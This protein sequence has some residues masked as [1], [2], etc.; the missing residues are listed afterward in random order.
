MKKKILF[1]VPILSGIGGIETSLINLVNNI[2]KEKYSVDICVY[3]NYIAFPERIPSSVK[4]IPGTK[5]MEYT[6][7]PL[8]KLSKELHGF[9]KVYLYIIKAIKSKFGIQK[10][11]RLVK[12]K[13]IFDNYDVAISFANDAV[14][15][16]Q[17]VGGGNEIVADCVNADKKLG[18]IHNEPY[19]CGCTRDYYENI[20]RKF[21]YVVNVSS[22]C[23]DMFDKIAPMLINKSKYV[24]NTF[25]IETI[26]RKSITDA[27]PLQEGI[28]NIVTVS[29]M[30]NNQKRIDRAIETCEILVHNGISNFH[31]TMIGDG[32]DLDYIKKLC[33]EKNISEY[34]T[35]TG[36]LS[37]PYPYIFSADVMVQP[38]D[39]E[40]YSMVLQEALILNTPLIVTNYPSASEAVNDGV[41]GY[42]VKK[43]AQEIAEKIL[44]LLKEPKELKRLNDNIANNPF[45]ND[46]AMKQFYSL[47]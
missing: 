35:F 44:K 31:W 36:K 47:L 23:K 18:W 34:M 40:A 1:V 3:G 41:N 38:S 9:S 7:V 2:D 24:Y 28:F 22:A 17:F 42:I 32:P 16:G 26:K 21:D 6:F 13:Y 43:D 33:K 12:H 29:R 27:N 4:I 5:E 46:V 8:K 20:Y 15:N 14:L 39:F 11:L 10:V 25:D 45:T 37:N 19:R 30:E